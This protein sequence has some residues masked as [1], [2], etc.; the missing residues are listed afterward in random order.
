VALSIPHTLVSLSGVRWHAEP[1]PYLGELRAI[2]TGGSPARIVG[3]NGSI[4]E[5]QP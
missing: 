3:T 5:F 2:D 4:L 1:I